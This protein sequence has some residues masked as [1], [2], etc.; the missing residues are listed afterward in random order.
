MNVEKI[1]AVAINGGKAIFKIVTR[2][3]LPLY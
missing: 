1:Y 2:K 3:K